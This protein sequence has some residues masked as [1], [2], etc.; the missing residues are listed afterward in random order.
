MIARKRGEEIKQTPKRKIP[1][2]Y[3][4]GGKRKTRMRHS[5]G[6][7]KNLA[8]GIPF[9]L[10]SVFVTLLGGGNF[11]PTFRLIF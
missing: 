9:D 3:S 6:G 8:F 2:R 11:L 1:M 5:E 7:G 4:E 10:I